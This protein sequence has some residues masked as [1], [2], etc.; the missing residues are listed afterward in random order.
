[1]NLLTM[2][3]YSDIVTSIEVAKASIEAQQ[4]NIDYYTR[5]LTS[6]PHDISGM[7][8]DGLPHG[9]SSSHTIDYCVERI[10]MAREKIEKTQQYVD[11]LTA[12]KEKIEQSLE[13]LEGVKNKVGIYRYIYNMPLKEIADK[14]G[15]SFDYVKHISASIKKTI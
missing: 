4:I 13:K 7:N 2:E 5:E 10:A 14:L 15:Y 3:D 8:M 11:K 6:A 1:M 12:A 9:N